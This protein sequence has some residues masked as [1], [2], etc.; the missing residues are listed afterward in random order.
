MALLPQYL[1]LHRDVCDWSVAPSL[2]GPTCWVEPR[3][4]VLLFARP[5]ADGIEDMTADDNARWS[6]D[7]RGSSSLKFRFYEGETSVLWA[8][9][10]PWRA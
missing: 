3:S 8:G 7:Q 9:G 10:R 6:R 4:V 5:D 1:S 2:E